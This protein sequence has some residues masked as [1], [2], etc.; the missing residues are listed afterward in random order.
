MFTKILFFS[1]TILLFFWLLLK[2][3]KFSLLQNIYAFF[4][5][6]FIFIFAFFA[7]WSVNLLQLPD[8]ITLFSAPLIEESSRF[9]LF[10]LLLKGHPFHTAQQKL[11][12]ALIAGLL[13]SILEGAGYLFTTSTS[14]F[15]LRQNLT[16]PLHIFLSMLQIR[17]KLKGFILSII[18]H[19]LYNISINTHI[20][21]LSLVQ[22][23]VISLWLIIFYWLYQSKPKQFRVF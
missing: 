16:T 22:F 9:L 6:F 3:F 13:F 19:S 4:L 15:L 23:L 21:F 2:G 7:S 10:S 12:L 14:A 8:I 1:S 5:S 17:Y 11:Q 20:I 18:I